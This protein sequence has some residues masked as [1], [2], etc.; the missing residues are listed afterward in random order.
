MDFYAIASTV[1]VLLPLIVILAVFGY[2]RG[3]Y[4]NIAN[5]GAFFFEGGALVLN[6]GVPYPIPVENIDCVELRC[7]G[8]ELENRLSYGLTVKVIRKDGTAK[9]CYYKGYRTAKLALPSDMAAEIEAHG[10]RCRLVE[11]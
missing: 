2:S 4:R 10:L 7:S 11:Q 8:W 9:S 1:C 6:T 3:R 5:A